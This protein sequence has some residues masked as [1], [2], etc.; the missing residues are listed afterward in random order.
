MAWAGGLAEGARMLHGEGL[1]QLGMRKGKPELDSH[2]GFP[3][4]PQTS[5]SR[6]FC[7]VGAPPT[8]V[9]MLIRSS[10]HLLPLLFSTFPFCLSSAFSL[11]Q[12]LNVLHLNIQSSSQQ[13]WIGPCQQYLTPASEQHGPQPAFCC[14]PGGGSSTLT[15]L[16]GSRASP[17]ATMGPCAGTLALLL[18]KRCLE[19][20]P[21]FVLCFSTPLSCKQVSFPP[22]HSLLSA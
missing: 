4:P 21:V 16:G 12:S 8:Q 18:G 20:V 14:H 19:A 15:W 9:P 7:I 11:L 2:T 1:C 10:L 6:D 17:E 5:A 13:G 22:P 3:A